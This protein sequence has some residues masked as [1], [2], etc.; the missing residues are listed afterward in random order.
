MSGFLLFL[1]PESVLCKVKKTT[2]TP[3]KKLCECAA[4]A[5]KAVLCQLTTYIA[6]VTSWNP[7]VS[8]RQFTIPPEVHP[9]RSIF[10]SWQSPN[11]QTPPR[12]LLTSVPLLL[13]DHIAFGSPTDPP[14]TVALPLLHSPLSYSTLRQAQSLHATQ[15]A[16]FS[17]PS[18]HLL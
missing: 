5:C 10:F 9:L 1:L 4:T 17:V 13:A 6:P 8:P 16:S 7:T 18:T 12:S 3:Q 14:R 11:G 15:T 2:S